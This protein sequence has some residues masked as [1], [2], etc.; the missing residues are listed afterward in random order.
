M[1]FISLGK[2]NL[3]VSKNSFG[4]MSL[5][6]KEIEAFGEEA[7][8]KSCAIVHHAYFGG[9][10]FFDTSHSKLV[11]EKR[12]GSA[13]H[14][15]RHNVILATK[16]SGQTAA[17]IRRD[18]NN[19]LFALETDYIDLYQIED[20]LVVPLKDGSDGLYNEMLTL[21]EKGIIRHIGIATENY[22]L[23]REAIECGLYETVQ[24]PFSMISPKEVV[25]LV[26]L[27]EKKDVGCIAMQPLN[28]G[29]VNNIPLAFG[30]FQQYENVVPVWG[31][32]TDEELQQ[33]LYFNNHPPVIDEEFKK[34]VENIRL[35]FN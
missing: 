29:I 32:H 1:E 27:C 11:C 9:M 3:L 16:T 2:S 26:T 5:D 13:L 10:N 8:E 34:E 19:S 7:D 33:I 28:G 17:E 12:L 18:L 21:K 6:C 23:V 30:F 20:P 14:G 22:D 35:F 25:E 15:I 4:A 31:T 24:F